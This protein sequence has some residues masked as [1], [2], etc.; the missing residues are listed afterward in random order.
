MR[1]CS[2]CIL[3]Y[4]YAGVK[5]YEKD[6]NLYCEYCIL[7]LNKKEEGFKNSAMEEWKS[8]IKRLKREQRQRISGAICIFRWKG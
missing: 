3:P 7:S 4:G 6:G 5:F 8:Y 2:K 1:L